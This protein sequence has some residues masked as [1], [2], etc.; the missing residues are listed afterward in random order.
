MNSTKD[1]Y[2]GAKRIVEVFEKFI[3]EY[4]L[5]DIAKADHI[6]YKCASSEDFEKL[7]GIFEMNCRWIHQSIIANRR[8]SLIKLNDS[9]STSIGDIDLLELSDQKPDGSQSNKFDHIEIF[10]VEVSYDEL[11]SQLKSRNLKVVEVVRP[12]HTTHDIDMGEGFLVR[13]TKKPLLDKIRD[14]EMS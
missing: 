11:V 8:I 10:P 14:E 4:N 12:H 6:C 1:F 7:R 3:I 5:G 9:I 2:G 13:L